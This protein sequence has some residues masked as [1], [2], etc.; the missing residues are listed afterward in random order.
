MLESA[1]FGLG[2]PKFGTVNA[3]SSNIVEVSG[4]GL[5]SRDSSVGIVE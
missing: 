4:G 2:F 1:I 5:T 3:G